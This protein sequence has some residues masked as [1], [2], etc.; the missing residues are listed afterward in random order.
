MAS[1]LTDAFSRA[2]QWTSQQCGRAHT[3]IIAIVIIVVWGA[4]GPAFGFSDTWQLLINT[5]TTIVTFLMVFLIQHT[6][7]RDTAAI[8]LKLDELIRA[9]QQARNRMLSLEDL[10]EDELKR[11]KESF[12]ELV[13]TSIHPDLVRD[14]KKDLEDAS[15][16]IGEA[17]E[18]LSKAGGA[19][20]SLSAPVGRRGPG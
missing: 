11:L 7:N 20:G 10:T 1:R 5:G 16:D 18:K 14:A 12:A 17:H 13:P 2:A 9:N 19:G 15:D 6:Q 4:S 3:F 8:Q